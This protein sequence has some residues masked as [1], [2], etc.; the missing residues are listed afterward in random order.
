M[1]GA[2]YGVEAANALPQKSASLT[3]TV[4][5]VFKSRNNNHNANQFFSTNTERMSDLDPTAHVFVRKVMQV[6][7][8]TCKKKNAEE[9]FKSILQDYA[10]KHKIEGTWPMWFRVEAQNDDEDDEAYPNEQPH[11]STNEHDD[12]WSDEI[13][14]LGPIGLL[15]ESMVW[16]GMRIDEDL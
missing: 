10:N 12:D 8:A 14:S 2:M 9:M 5:D 4:I 6:R 1:H 13:I 7:R 16:H 3:A 11:S 15:V